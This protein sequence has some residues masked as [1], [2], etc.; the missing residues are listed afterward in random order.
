MAKLYGSEAAMRHTTKA[1]QIYG[2][3]GYCKGAKV[4]RLFRDAKFT[5]IG[6]GT[7]EAQRMVISGNVLR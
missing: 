4:E 5:E 2:G 1:V 7:S 3:Y 6:E